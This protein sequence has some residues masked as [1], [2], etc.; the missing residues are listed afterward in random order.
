MSDHSTS[1]V[2]KQSYYPNRVA[3]AKEIL[4]WLTSQNIVQL[5]KS[6]CTLGEEGYALSTGAQQVTDLPDELPVDLITNGLE[7][8]TER[9]VF[10]TGGNRVD[11][12]IC[13]A[14]R[15]NITFDEWDVNPWAEREGDTMECPRCE[16]KSEV[17]IYRFEPEWGFSD[18]GFTFWNWPPFSKGFIDEFQSRLGCEMAIV[19][20]QI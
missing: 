19:Y 11:Q 16:T 6:D 20:Q 1:F 10:D 17:H 13:P 8:V 12:L 3:K 15:E 7:I 5:A 4:D 18:L 9:Q 2:P 14:C